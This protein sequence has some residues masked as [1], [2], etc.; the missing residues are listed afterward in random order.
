MA[1]R[2][3]SLDAVVGRLAPRVLRKADRAPLSPAIDAE[4]RHVDTWSAGRLA[5]YVDA[6]AAGRPVVLLHAI[7]AAASSKEVAPLFDAL[8]AERPVY[9]L[10]LPGFGLSERA[11]R[12]YDRELYRAAVRRFLTDVVRE[13]D[14][15]DVIALS[16]SS[17]FAAAVA[18]EDTSLVHSLVLVSPTGLGR[19][20]PDAGF[21][22]RA[23][24]HVPHLSEALFR[25]LVTPASIRW[26]L[27]KS[28]VG[29]PD[30]GLVDYAVRTSREP[31]AHRAPLA[32]IAGDMF[33]E[34]A[35]ERFYARLPV[36][37]LVVHD[38]DPHA[39][40]DRLDELAQ[41]NPRVESARV[42]PTRGLPHFEQRD[43]TLEAVRRF[44]TQDPW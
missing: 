38:R 14:G 44:W 20:A 41:Q 26:F 16:L 32:F 22:L 27:K 6:R 18:C 1:A 29:E 5:Y 23:V 4:I 24:A 36:P 42:A 34:D 30:P 17:E 10:D 33:T 9:A 7:N 25:A 2:A 40:F 37:T 8:R 35:F 12:A 15:A 43:A 21:V 19:E 11:D 13:P 28:F 3:M 31:G 39:R